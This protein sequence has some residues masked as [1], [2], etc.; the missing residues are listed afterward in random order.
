MLTMWASV[1]VKGWQST[2]IG[3]SEFAGVAGGRSQSMG[4][5]ALT[6]IAT[7]ALHE[8]YREKW[9]CE[10]GVLVAIEGDE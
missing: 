6:V 5:S 3:W 10:G 4:G 2:E 9:W 7:V 8:Q 1:Y